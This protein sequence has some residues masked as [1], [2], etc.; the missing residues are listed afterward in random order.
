MSMHAHGWPMLHPRLLMGW[1]I[2]AGC[3]RVSALV[4]LA[5]SLPP[6]SDACDDDAHGDEAACRFDPARGTAG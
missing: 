1:P 4:T 5:A 6:A 3:M 2:H